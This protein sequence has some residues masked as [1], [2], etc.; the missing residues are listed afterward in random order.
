[1]ALIII[2][3]ANKINIA[4]TKSFEDG[5]I[6]LS[7]FI[8]SEEFQLKNN[9]DCFLVDTLFKK[10]VNFYDG[11]I[12]EALLA[13]TFSTLPFNKMPVTIP[14]L[15]LKLDLKLPAVNEELFQIKKDN[16]PGIIYFDSNTKGNQDKDKVAHFFGNAFLSYNISYF[17]L[18]KFLGMFVE[19]FESIFKVSGGIDPRDLHT[20]YLGE[21]FGES[22]KKNKELVPSDFFKLYSLFYFSYN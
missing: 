6:F 21:F 14:I 4:Q 19:M 17:N 13:L 22:I 7:K 3:F 1:M 11:D 9:P 15:N 5:V 12:S 18:S 20:N 16:L 8:A 10:A 2:F